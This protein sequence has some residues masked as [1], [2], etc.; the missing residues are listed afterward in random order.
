MSTD[1][2][3]LTEADRDALE[4]MPSGWFSADDLPYN[5]RC[6]R[7]RCERLRDRGKLEWRVVGQHPHLQ[8]E[9]R[10]VSQ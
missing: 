2:P 7:F 8:S 9:Y 6:P 1:T 3:T 4:Q 5:I 10:K